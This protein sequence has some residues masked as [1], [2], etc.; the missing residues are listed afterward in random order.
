MDRE[1]FFVS[2]TINIGNEKNTSFWEAKW[3]QG[4]TPKEIAPSLFKRA[5]FKKRSV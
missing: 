5:R 3:L 2:T 4:S 1:L